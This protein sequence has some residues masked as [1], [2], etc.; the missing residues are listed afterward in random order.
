M[1]CHRESRK[2]SSLWILLVGTGYVMLVDAGTAKETHH[3]LVS[4]LQG[5]SNVELLDPC[6]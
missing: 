6:P 4:V 1:G 2:L 5:S 3:L